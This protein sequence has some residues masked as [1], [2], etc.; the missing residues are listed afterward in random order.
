MYV[1]MCVYIYIGIYIYIHIIP[2]SLYINLDVCIYIYICIYKSI[3]IYIYICIYRSI[4]RS[5][6]GYHGRPALAHR[7]HRR[8]ARRPKHLH[9]G[10]PHGARD[11]PR[12]ADARQHEQTRAAEA[13]SRSVAKRRGIP[14]VSERSTRCVGSR[15]VHRV[16]AV[17]SMWLPELDT[18][19]SLH[20]IYALISSVS[21]LRQVP[22]PMRAR[23][24][25]K[26]LTVI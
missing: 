12:P 4:D 18:E 6:D 1:C 22:S 19:T 21:Q 23:R 14:R 10:D 8:L 2:L 25:T 24:K 9:A 15:K 11:R 3:H 16:S 7:R 5:I 26:P 17:L 13:V 20:M